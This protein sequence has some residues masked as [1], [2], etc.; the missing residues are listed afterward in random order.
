MGDM[1]A[2]SD[3]SNSGTEWLR[4]IEGMV[5]ETV[6]WFRNRG[7]RNQIAIELTALALGLT[8]RKTRSLLYQEPVATVREEYLSIRRRFR[9][10]LALQC[11]DLAR[12]SEAARHRYLQMEADLNE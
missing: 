2:R 5:A 1:M 11:A 3:F 7:H 12:R 10:H 9:E 8:T 4:P 6:V